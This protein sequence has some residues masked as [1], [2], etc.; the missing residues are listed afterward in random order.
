[1]TDYL[2][3][4]NFR[5]PTTADLQGL[6]VKDEFLMDSEVVFDKMHPLMIYLLVQL[7]KRTGIP[8]I[9]N[10]T[11]RSPEKNRRVGGARNSR[12]LKGQ[13]VD[14]RVNSSKDRA[15]F[16][17]EAL[18]LGLSVGVMRNALHVDIRAFDT[19]GIKFDESKQV[20]FHY[21]N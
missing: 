18:N 6:F 14:F 7:R 2:S 19:P 10:S 3:N 9:L 15:T 4:S 5:K 16:I 20:V 8:M 11:Y 12:H 13:A 1:M 21:Y 17:K